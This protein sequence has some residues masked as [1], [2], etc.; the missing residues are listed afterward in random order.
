[1]NYKDLTVYLNIENGSEL[2]YFEEMADLIESDEPIDHDAL[3]QLFSEIDTQTVSELIDNYFNDITDVLPGEHSDMYSLLD[4][5]RLELTGCVREI[6]PEDPDSVQAFT[7]RFSRFR[8]WYVYD[9]E[10]Y[11]LERD[12]EGESPDHEYTQSVRDAIV[13]AR[14]GRFSD[15]EFEFDFSDALD[16]EIDY[17]T[18]SF[19][20]LIEA[21]DA[22]PMEN[23]LN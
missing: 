21:E 16:Y 4:Q 11:V 8:S 10:V 14:A 18:V 17:Y 9:T 20:D 13:T 6:D 3:M 5:I 19:S 12:P 23:D 15:E 7:D 2:Q 1:M 22:D